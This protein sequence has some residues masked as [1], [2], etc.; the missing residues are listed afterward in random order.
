MADAPTPR[1][2]EI[3]QRGV[4]VRGVDLVMATLQ[5]LFPRRVFPK[6]EDGDR[7][8]ILGEPWRRGGTTPGG[9]SFSGPVDHPEGFQN[10][11]TGNYFIGTAEQYVDAGEPH[12]VVWTP[13]APG[14]ERFSPATA[15]GFI[16]T[17]A[18]PGKPGFLRPATQQ[19]IAAHEYHSQMGRLQRDV[20]RALPNPPFPVPGVTPG[21]AAVPGAPGGF[22]TTPIVPAFVRNRIVPMTAHIWGNDWDDTEE[23]VLWLSCAAETVF[24]GTIPGVGIV[25]SGGWVRD[26]KATRGLHYQLVVNFSCPIVWP[27]MKQAALLGASVSTAIAE[28]VAR[29]E[30]DGPAKR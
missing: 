12:R 16:V 14:Q 6:G 28:P 5:E 29:P 22:M 25:E 27:P 2:I 11:T 8:P 3:A 15:A 7:R 20:G 13:P 24:Q 18:E 21:G 26:E 19:E 23:I 10:L 30:Y 1:Q 9:A 17:Q 4:I